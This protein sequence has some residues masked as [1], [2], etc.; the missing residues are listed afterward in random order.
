MAPG[1]GFPAVLPH[2]QQ[3]EQRFFYYFDI[4][5]TYLPQN[6]PPTPPILLI[7]H[8]THSLLPLNPLTPALRPPLP[9]LGPSLALSRRGAIKVHFFGRINADLL[10]FFNFLVVG[11]CA[12]LVD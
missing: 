2:F 10:L 9:L 5:G 12:Q 4:S 1:S 7:Q 11:G 8:N 3:G 6:P